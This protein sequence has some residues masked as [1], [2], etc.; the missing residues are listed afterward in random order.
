MS[1]IRTKNAGFFLVGILLPL[2]GM[3]PA[4]ADDSITVSITQRLS[5]DQNSQ[6]VTTRWH[7]F[8]NSYVATASGRPA[9][10]T[11]FT[12][13]GPAWNWTTSEYQFVSITPSTDG[14]QCRASLISPLQLHDADGLTSGQHNI[15][16]T[17]TATWI[18]EDAT[19][20]PPVS[21]I[22]PT[23][24]QP[25]K[26]SSTPGTITTPYFVTVPAHV[27]ILSKDNSYFPGTAG[28]P[29]PWGHVTTYGFKL[30]DNQAVPQ[31]YVEASS[32]A[33]KF[34]NSAY[35]ST[36]YGDVFKTRS[37]GAESNGTF[38]FNPPG[39][40]HD[41]NSDG[42]GSDTGGPYTLWYSFDQTWSSLESSPDHR[43][44]DYTTA[45]N[46]FRI[47]HFQYVANRDYE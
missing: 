31:L 44:S 41:Q 35:P 11:E 27:D 33:E 12:Y 42:Y 23:T 43:N 36:P 46:T 32:M 8:V 1:N 16:V 13:V 15:A 21:I 47:T 4:H 5:S 25:I 29:R 9:E 28:A 45:L 2:A 6:F 3:S 7:Q 37:P 17:A 14:L 39:I 24:N 22:D 26:V 38:G 10:T 20:N 30:N 19:K 18:E 40:F 34:S